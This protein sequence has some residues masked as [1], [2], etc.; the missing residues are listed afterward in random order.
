LLIVIAVLIVGAAGAGVYLNTGSHS[1]VSSSTSTSSSSLSTSHSTANASLFKI[2][3]VELYVGF[4]GGLFDVGFQDVGGKQVQSVV[5]ILSTPTEVAL[6]TGAGYGLQFANC[7]PGPGKT[8]IAGVASVS[9]SFAANATF[10]GFATGKGPG[11]ALLGQN[12]TF[13]VTAVLIDKTTVVSTY[14]V[15]ATA[16]G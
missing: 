8:Y 11:S 10:A 1:T 14:T 6:C 16:G 7:E 9:G 12:Y 5:V 13:T 3:F 15:Q 4:S 2:N